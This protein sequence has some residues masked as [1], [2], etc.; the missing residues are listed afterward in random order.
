ML[1]EIREIL[2][3]KLSRTSLERVA[4]FIKNEKVSGNFE[5]SVIQMR[6]DLEKI[7]LTLNSLKGNYTKEK[8]F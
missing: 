1:S 7:M 8:N 3:Q 2:D 4:E 5:K 6:G